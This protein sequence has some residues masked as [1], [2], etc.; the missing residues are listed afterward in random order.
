MGFEILPLRDEA[1]ANFC[2]QLSVQLWIQINKRG[3]NWTVFFALIP[4][5]PPTH[6]AL[7]A[8]S[9]EAAT[10]APDLTPALNQPLSPPNSKL[11]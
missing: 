4:E 1:I 7:A 6:L 11:Y 8:T 2:V 10:L 5:E 9:N 3:I